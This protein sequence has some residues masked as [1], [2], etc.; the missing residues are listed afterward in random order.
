MLVRADALPTPATGF[1]TD[2]EVLIRAI[3]AV[4]ASASALDL[5]LA[6]DFAERSLSMGGSRRGEIVFAGAGRTVA[7]VEQPPPNLRILKVNEKGE[8]CGIRKVGLRRAAKD[9]D[10]WEIYVSARN[11]GA[12][13]RN[14]GITL[15]FGNAPIGARKVTI[16]AGGEQSATFQYRTRAAGWLEARLNQTDNFPEDDRAVLELPEQQ[17]LIVAVYTNDADLFRP[18]L[19]ADSRVEARFYT[20]AEYSDTH[21]PDVAILDRFRPERAPRVPSLWIEPPREGSPVPVRATT[22][23]VAV[24]RWRSDHPLGA[25]LH[26]EDLR[27]ETAAVFAAA[28]TDIRVAEADT[29]PLV[30]AREAP[31]RTIVM[32]FNPVRSTMRYELATPLLFANVLRWMAPDVFRQQNVNV[33]HAGSVTVPVSSEFEPDKVK[34]VDEQN[35]PVPFSLS[36]RSLRFFAAKPGTVRVQ[37]PEGES[38][39]SL[40]LPDAG[41]ARWE[42][43]AGA[44]AGL[45]RGRSLVPP[46]R[47]LWRGLAL[48]GGLA[49]LVEWMIYGRSRG[50]MR[51]VPAATV[52]L[53]AWKQRLRKPARKAS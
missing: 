16:P 12:S 38:V 42:P 30:V 44:R 33:G 37:T 23:D 14:V 39:H 26:T 4:E 27:L 31:L 34:V 41:E 15:Y 51:R 18:V 40:T 9:A 10:L 36:G 53:T 1:E 8:N 24:R 7:Q 13:T 45:P 49:L 25:G 47:D 2:R 43:P 28:P 20:P 22:A 5:S 29:G 19:A 3:R 48:L 17:R 32:G 11:Y 52:G 50:N 46:A 35:R 21:R 6:F